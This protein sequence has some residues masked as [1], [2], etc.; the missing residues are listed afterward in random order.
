[1]EYANKPSSTIIKRKKG[2]VNP[3]TKLPV[4][5]M[6]TLQHWNSVR[7]AAKEMM[8][9]IKSTISSEKTRIQMRKSVLLVGGRDDAPGFE[10]GRSCVSVS[11]IVFR[12]GC[13]LV[14]D[15]ELDLD[16]PVVQASLLTAGTVFFA[17]TLVCLPKLLLL[18]VGCLVGFFLT[19]GFFAIFVLTSP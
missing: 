14:T 3:K 11:F 15:T 6:V 10:V 18:E 17:P 8:V 1:M 7:A 2:T 19:R 13:L 12:S 5:S 9:V 4:K 16:D